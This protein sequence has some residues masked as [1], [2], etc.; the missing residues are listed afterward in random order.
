MILLAIGMPTPLGQ[1]QKVQVCEDCCR[2]VK[3][4]EDLVNVPL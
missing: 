4:L 3:D 1:A 2:Q